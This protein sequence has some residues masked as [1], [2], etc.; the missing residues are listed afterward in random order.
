MP[1]D[2]VLNNTKLETIHMSLNNMQQ[3]T[4]E[5]SHLRDLK[6]L[7]MRYNSIE[8][9][10][11]FSRDSL[12]KLYNLQEQIHQPAAETS[13]LVVD[14]RGNPFSCD[15][16][17]MEFLKW[18]VN[19]PIVSPTRH[20]YFCKTGGQT[21]SMT[22][23]AI[24]AAEYDCERPRRRLRKIILASVH[25]MCGLLVI[26]L[27]TFCI[28]KQRKKTQ[29]QRRFEDRVKLLQDD[30]LSVGFFVFLSFSID[31]ERFVATNVLQPLKVW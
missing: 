22:V 5:I 16:R 3:I 20:M 28:I 2:T 27:G 19:S 31:D 14:L 1:A 30:A 10:N 8:T 25:V 4:F 7:D 21:Y 26:L 11:A 12:D 23:D 6:I 29:L 17:S 18:F 15:C 9:L 24:S 13:S